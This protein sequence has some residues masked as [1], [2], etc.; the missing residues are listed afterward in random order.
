MGPIGVGDL[1][2]SLGLQRR[3]SELRGVLNRLTQELASGRTSDVSKATAGNLSPLAGIERSLS[4]VNAYETSA[5]MAAT[6]LSITG[7]ALGNVRQSVDALGA[8]ILGATSLNN[9]SLRQTLSGGA[10]AFEAA[11]SSLSARSGDTFLFSGTDVTQAPFLPAQDML[12]EL[13]TLTAGV[14]SSTDFYAAIDDWFLAPGSGF[15]TTGYL[16]G[17]APATGRSVSATETVPSE[18][19]A[20]DPAIRATLRDLA[21]VALIDRNAFAGDQDEVLALSQMTATGLISGAD[22][23]VQ[24]EAKQGALAAR[25]D[26]AQ[27]QNAAERFSFEE[28]R[29]AVLG[30]DLFDTATQLEDA[31]TRLESLYLL[32]AKTSRLS[33]TEYLR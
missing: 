12:Q 15:E 30:I 19:T 27:A 3:N 23:L 11:I 25:V 10:G 16:G 13:E 9:A 22:A 4:F 7:S 24:L 21:V 14:T 2:A 17:D 33:L 6:A 20:Q 28:A 32:T 1:Q 8:E 31:Q 5:N 18:L 29:N 26:Q